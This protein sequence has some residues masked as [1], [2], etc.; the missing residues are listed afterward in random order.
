[1]DEEACKVEYR[2]SSDS[3]VSSA[4]VVQSAV[5]CLCSVILFFFT[6]AD[7]P[8]RNGCEGVLQFVTRHW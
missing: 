8:S 4:G 7:D 2:L 6:V 3:T 5:C 1:M